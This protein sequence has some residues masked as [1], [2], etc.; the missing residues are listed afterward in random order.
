MPKGEYSRPFNK[1]LKTIQRSFGF[2]G[3]GLAGEAS[4]AMEEQ[5]KWGARIPDNPHMKKREQER[6]LG[7]AKAVEE[8]KKERSVYN[9]KTQTWT[10]Q[11]MPQS[12]G[13]ES[14][15]PKRKK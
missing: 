6:R 4:K 5:R 13:P 10:L 12:T 2:K 1:D 11:G 9:W 3:S 8:V 14:P 7:N 15:P